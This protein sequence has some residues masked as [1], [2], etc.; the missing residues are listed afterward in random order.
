[1]GMTHNSAVQ[2]LFDALKCTSMARTA[3]MSD[4]AEAAQLIVSEG[5]HKALTRHHNCC[6]GIAQAQSYAF[7]RYRQLS[8][9]RTGSQ[10]HTASGCIKLTPYAPAQL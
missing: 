7:M 5:N 3:E 10:V 6:S 8:N 4:F 9:S 1:M 2:L